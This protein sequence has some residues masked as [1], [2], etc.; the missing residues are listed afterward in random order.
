MVSCNSTG[1]GLCGESS[2]HPLMS[3]G[4]S[5]ER[6]SSAAHVNPCTV[7]FKVGLQAT[8]KWISLQRQEG[9]ITLCVITQQKSHRGHCILL[10]KVV[11][12]EADGSCW[13][14]WSLRLSQI[15]KFEKSFLHCCSALTSTKALVLS[16]N[17]V[18]VYMSFSSPLFLLS[19]ERSRLFLLL[20]NVLFSC[21]ITF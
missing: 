6:W 9:Q 1:D 10:V 21:Q 20:L 14:F 12:V 13:L 17:C 8:W 2:N 7:L 19:A 15:A 4:L 3:S 18:A 5:W 11:S 16:R